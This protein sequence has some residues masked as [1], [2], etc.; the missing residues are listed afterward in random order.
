MRKFLLLCVSVICCG[1]ANAQWTFTIDIKYSGNCG[2]LNGIQGLNALSYEAAYKN[3]QIPTK[4]E[5]E[6]L[7]SQLSS[8]KQGYGGCY[9]QIVCGPCTGQDIAGNNS[10]DQ[11][12]NPNIFGPSQGTAF[13]PSSAPDATKQWLEDFM[14]KFDNYLNN[15]YNYANNYNVGGDAF[16]D[17]FNLEYAQVSDYSSADRNALKK[18][19]DSVSIYHVEYKDD[20][21]DGKY[22]S[23]VV[24]EKVEKKEPELDQYG[25]PLFKGVK[26][27]NVLPDLPNDLSAFEYKDERTPLQKQLDEYNRKKEM[28]LYP[29]NESESVLGN[30]I[31]WVGKKWEEENFSE[32]LTGWGLEKLSDKI[33]NTI[34]YLA[35]KASPKYT[36]QA[37]E[38]KEIHEDVVET[39]FKGISDMANKITSP[40]MRNTAEK[41]FK[42]IIFLSHDVESR[43]VDAAW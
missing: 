14:K 32:K 9:A 13:S 27:E 26:N 37:K 43:A 25:R 12:A 30:A 21:G 38:I 24:E 40:Q 19:D 7:R 35:E 29:A 36:A 5:C 31:G 34:E 11:N 15:L 20:R 23:S 16:E 41:N 42:S 10:T 22:I 8:I 39:I 6:A 2:G 33:E 3:M 17:Y 4:N 18:D 1:F 28:E